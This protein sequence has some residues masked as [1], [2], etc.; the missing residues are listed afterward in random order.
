MVSP[1][2]IISDGGYG[3]LGFEGGTTSHLGL[4]EWY[5][6]HVAEWSKYASPQ[7]TLW[8][9]NSEIGW[10]AVHPVLEKYGWRY[11]NCNVWNKTKAHIAGNINT[12]LGFCGS[13]VSSRAEWLA[14]VE[15]LCQF[16]IARSSGN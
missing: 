12:Q 1:T 6:P 14:S 10:A 7:T 15:D 2:G 8:F 4:P 5:E 16:A 13:V 3:A 9:W 11:Q